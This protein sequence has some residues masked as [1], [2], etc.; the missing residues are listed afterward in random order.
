[1]D[2]HIISKTENKSENS[3]NGSG[4]YQRKLKYQLEK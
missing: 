3:R 1:M 2:L 4:D